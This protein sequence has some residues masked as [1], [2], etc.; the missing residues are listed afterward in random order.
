MLDMPATTIITS[1]SPDVQRKFCLHFTGGGLALPEQMQ[2]TSPLATAVAP[3]KSSSRTSS[4]ALRGWV[5]FVLVACGPVARRSCWPTV[6]TSADVGHTADR[7]CSLTS[8][9]AARA[10]WGRVTTGAD[11]LS[12]GGG[13]LEVVS[14][15]RGR[16]TGHQGPLSVGRSQVADDRAGLIRL[17]WLPRVHIHEPTLSAQVTSSDTPQ[18][19]CLQVFG[20][21][22]HPQASHQARCTRSSPDMPTNCGSPDSG[23]ARERG[24]IS[25]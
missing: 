2:A 15:L 5:C 20:S 25:P 9:N 23:T 21:M 8:R 16:D 17:P 19:V 7:I 14:H 22:D 18:G 11:R 13:K 10:G 3:G 4:L 12:A 1:C 6:R 24:R